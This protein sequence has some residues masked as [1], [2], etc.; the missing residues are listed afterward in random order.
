MK[1]LAAMLMFIIMLSAF[2]Y[3]EGDGIDIMLMNKIDNYILGEMETG[4]IPSVALGIVKRDEVFYLRGYG[5]A[6]AD[7]V[8][9]I[10]SLS[11]TFTAL[12]IRQLIGRGLI[13]ESDTVGMH[14]DGFDVTD[15]GGNEI[16]IKSLLTHTSGYSTKSGVKEYT[17]NT[18]Y[19]IDDLVW[20]IKDRETLRWNVGEKYEYSNLNYIILGRVVETVSGMNYEDYIKKNIYEPLDMTSSYL[21]GG[22]ARDNLIEG[23]RYIYNMNLKT[24]FPYP[25]GLV[26]SG[27]QMSTARDMS[28]YLSSMLNGGYGKVE[29]LIPGNKIERYDNFTE[30]MVHYNS[31]WMPVSETDIESYNKFYG[32]VGKTPNYNSAILVNQETGYGIV[33]L[34]NQYNGYN[35][36]EITARSIGNGITDILTRGRAMNTSLRWI[37]Y[38][39][40]IVPLFLVGFIV[41]SVLRLVIFLNKEEMTKLGVL[42]PIARI[43]LFIAL[44]IVIPFIYDNSWTYLKGSTPEYFIPLF[45]V[46]IFGIIIDAARLGIHFMGHYKLK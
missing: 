44:I 25:G 32:F 28:K 15:K 20:L 45:A 39:I 33:I 4:E 34:I 21:G 37:N 41:A 5:D 12:A 6:N 13:D 31:I 40:W 14:I 11:K 29:S 7:T 30:G 1:R 17:Y 46:F 23:Y 38:V 42:I 26:A 19:D 10:G 16:T 8:F 36:P 27:Y 22:W 2:S 18:K 35:E 24:S 3:A 9:V 43:I